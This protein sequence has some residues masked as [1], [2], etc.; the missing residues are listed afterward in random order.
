MKSGFSGPFLLLP[1]LLS[2]TVSG[3]GS[4]V[5]RYYVYNQEHLNWQEAQSYCRNSNT[6]LATIKTQTDEDSLHLEEYHAWIGLY[7]KRDEELAWSNGESSNYFLPFTHPPQNSSEGC[8]S[9]HYSEK[10]YHVRRC[11]TYYFFFCHHP[12][13]NNLDYELILQSK[14]WSEA[15]QYCKREFTDLATFRSIEDLNTDVTE[16][17]FQ[18]WTGLHRDGETWRWSTGVSD[19]RNWVED[20]PGN[21]GDCVSISSLN[22]EMAT[23]NCSD[24]FPFVCI[25]DNLVL[26]KENKTWR[27]ALDHCRALNSPYNSNIRFELVS[28]QPEDHDNVINKVKE[29]DTEE[30]WAGLRFL[31]GH[32]VWVNGASMVYSHL[33]PCP[34]VE[35]GCGVLSKNGTGRVEITDCTEKRNFLCYSSY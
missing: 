34:P 20:E 17:V 26:V 22:K 30:V 8:V 32:W 25:R 15:L 19:F 13:G 4:V 2:S 18:V 3:L 5:Q 14:T 6:D 21:N 1:L 10:K 9:V 31:A 23:Q 12:H 11:E 35:Q 33:P 7:N 29:G 16:Q 28:V 27:E 24:R